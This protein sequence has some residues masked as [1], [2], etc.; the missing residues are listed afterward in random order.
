MGHVIALQPRL[1]PREFA[2]DAF[3]EGRSSD[4]LAALRGHDEPAARF[5]AAR[6]ANRL[7]RHGQAL[8]ELSPIDEAN[9][10]TAGR[11]EYFV[12]RAEA[13]TGLGRFAE[14]QG[15]LSLARIHAFG[16]PSAALEA[17]VHI[18]AA[19]WAFA[20]D[21]YA[22]AS[23]CA[24]AALA[25]SPSRFDRADYIVP[26]EHSRARALHSLGVVEAAGGRYGAQL[27]LLR[28]ALAELDAARPGDAWTRANLLMNL[29]FYVRDF[30]LEADAEWL[31]GELEAAWPADLGVQRFYILRSLGWSAALHGNS[32]G[33][34]RAFRRAVEIAPTPALEVWAHADRAYLSCQLGEGAFA[35]DELEHGAELAQR[36]DWNGIA[37][38]DRAALLHLAKQTASVAPERARALFESYRRIKTPL[39]ATL[40]NKNDRRLRAHEAFADGVIARAENAPHVAREKLTDAFE[41]WKAIDYR[42]QAA[43]AAIELSE[44]GAGDIYRDYA[45]AEAAARPRSWLVRRVAASET[46]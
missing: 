29:S 16:T 19:R 38:D 3:R 14:A 18:A 40:L 46:H 13:L 24:R 33:A 6:S 20:G 9:L 39:S 2:V 28:S 31:H 22:T 30:D 5:L 23:V 15:A 21:D 25:A 26:L 11:A 42:W 43:T 7:G 8:A 27:A 35:R 10:L 17:D 4:C 32:I 34:F 37:G 36:I 41:I 1:K 12:L 44:L 45:R